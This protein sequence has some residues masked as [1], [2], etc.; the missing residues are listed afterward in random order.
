[1]FI[2]D[3][4]IAIL[5]AELAK[6]EPTSVHFDEDR[7]DVIGPNGNDGLHYQDDAQEMARRIE[8]DNMVLRDVP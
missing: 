4:A 1:M 6:P 3:R 8:L 7:M 2:T 5:E